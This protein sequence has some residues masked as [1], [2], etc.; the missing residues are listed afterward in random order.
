VIFQRNYEELGHKITN[1]H[2]HHDINYPSLDAVD[3][4]WVCLDN[5]IRHDLIYEYNFHAAVKQQ[6]VGKYGKNCIIYASS[7]LF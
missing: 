2:Y 4:S 3:F 7:G 6:K 1:H 5:N